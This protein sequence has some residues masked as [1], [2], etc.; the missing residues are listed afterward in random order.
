MSR[1]EGK[2]NGWGGKRFGEGDG[3]GSQMVDAL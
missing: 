2:G 3:L 1:G